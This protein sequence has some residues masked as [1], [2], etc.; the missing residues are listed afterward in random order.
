MRDT[1]QHNLLTSGSCML[2]DCIIADIHLKKHF[3]AQLCRQYTQ[4]KAVSAV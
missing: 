4:L 2:I 1:D 3:E